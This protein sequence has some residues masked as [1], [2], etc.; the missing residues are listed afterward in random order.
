MVF[1]FFAGHG[2]LYNGQQNLLIN[3]FDPEK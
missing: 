3:E 1:H 2:M